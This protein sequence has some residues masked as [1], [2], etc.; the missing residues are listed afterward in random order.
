MLC[1]WGL[2]SDPRYSVC[3]ITGAQLINT[4]FEFIL[5][6]SVPIYRF[7]CGHLTLFSPLVWS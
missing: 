3:K 6:T 5:G 2:T 1:A 7:V 4:A